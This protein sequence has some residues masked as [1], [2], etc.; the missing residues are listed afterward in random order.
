MGGALG[1]CANFADCE[2]KRERDKPMERLEKSSNKEQTGSGAGEF[3]GDWYLSCDLYLG[4]EVERVKSL[5]QEPQLA[6]V[7]I[8]GPGPSSGPGQ[9]VDTA[10]LGIPSLEKRQVSET[11]SPSEWWPD[12]I[13]SCTGKHSWCNLRRDTHRGK[14]RKT[15]FLVKSIIQGLREEGQRVPLLSWK[16]VSSAQLL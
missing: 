10:G 11:N 9:P 8:P 12:T 13:S 1:L 2:V 4:K 3:E 15:R 16:C 7:L 14:Q 6:E 5:S